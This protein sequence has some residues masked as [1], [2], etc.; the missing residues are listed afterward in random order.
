MQFLKGYSLDE[1]IAKKAIPTIPQVLRIAAE[2]AAGLAAAH[3]IGLIHRDIKPGNLWLVA[4]RGRVKILDFGLAK[5]VDSDIE[6]TRSGTIIGT[7]A[8]MSPEQ[9]RGREG[10]PPHRS[11][12]PGGRDVSAVYRSVT[13]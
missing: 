3:D 8:Y 12:Q 2:T 13:V 11:V 9:V 7:P 1:Y 4:P 5:P 10:G 6:L